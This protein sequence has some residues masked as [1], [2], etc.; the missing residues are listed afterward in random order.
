MRRVSVVA[1]VSVLIGL[2]PVFSQTSSTAILGTVT[3]ASGAVLVGA[4][5]TLLQVQTGIKR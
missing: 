2:V 5:V 4:K 3:D 1:I